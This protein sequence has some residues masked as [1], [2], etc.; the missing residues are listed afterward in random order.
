MLTKEEVNDMIEFKQTHLH[1][2]REIETFVK[3]ESSIM[4]LATLP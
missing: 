2:F 3:L 4:K 1:R